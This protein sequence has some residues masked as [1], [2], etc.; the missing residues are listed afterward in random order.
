[1]LCQILMSD[2]VFWRWTLFVILIKLKTKDN[3][4]KAIPV[5]FFVYRRMRL[6]TLGRSVWLK[7]KTKKKITRSLGISGPGTPGRRQKSTFTY[8]DE[9]NAQHTV[10]NVL[11]FVPVFLYVVTMLNLEIKRIISSKKRLNY[12]VT[13]FFFENAKNLDRSDDSKRR[14]KWGWPNVQFKRIKPLLSNL[15]FII[16]SMIS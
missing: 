8:L 10:K 14:K 2:P 3:N 9:Q 16:S 1:M 11:V 15:E 5:F 7:K 4:K 12:V 13:F 6:M